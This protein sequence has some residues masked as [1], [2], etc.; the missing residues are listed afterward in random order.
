[1]LLQKYYL[2]NINDINMKPE[3][4]I[5]GDYI[6][7]NKDIYKIEEISKK[8]WAHLIHNDGKQLSCTTIK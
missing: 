8:G 5:I 6:L 4:L 3:Q 7:F 1:M 2:K